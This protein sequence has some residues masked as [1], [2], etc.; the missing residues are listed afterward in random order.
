MLPE[1]LQQKLDTLPNSAGVYYFTGKRGEPLY[2]GKAANLRSRVRSYFQ[3]GNSDQRYFIDR[4]ARELGDIETFVT[5]T[6]REA[7]L[8]E[9]GLIKEH[10]PRYNVKL[11]DDKEYLSLRLDPAAA[12]PR[13]EVVRRPRKDG[14]QYFGPYHSATAARSTLRV[15]NRH[16]QL[17]T[18]TDR[19]LESR[20]RPCLQYQIKRC[21]GPCVYEIDQDLY[22]AQVRNVG[23][24]LDGRHDEL[25]E[26]LSTAMAGAATELKYEL[27]A[28]YR[29]QLRALDATAQKQRVALVSDID[30]DVF[31]F[32]R[33]KDKAELAVVMSRRGRVVGVR[34]FAL[35]Q[36]QIPDDELLSAFVREY[37]SH[38]TF[39]PNEVIVPLPLEAEVG[40]S[41]VLG[42]QAGH[43]VHIVRPQRGARAQ[44]LRMA[45]ENA[46]HAFNEKARAREDIDTRLS[47]VQSRLQLPR[48]PQRF[49]CVDVSHLGGG[50]TVAAVVSFFDGEPER[51]R[52]RSFH[53]KKV[54]GGDDYGAM[55]EVLSRRFRRAKRGESGWE[56]P[57]LLVVDG[58]KG[59]LGIAQQVLSE[60]ELSD[61]PVAGLAKEKQNVRGEQLVDRLY[62]PGRMNAI[63]LSSAGAAFNM[64]AYA[65][66]EAHRASNALRL[67]L[68]K[69]RRLRSRLDDIRGVGPKTRSLL[70]TAFGDLQGVEAANMEQL[71]AAGATR[72]QASAIYTHFHGDAREA[73][74]SEED[75]IDNAFD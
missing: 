32:Y 10:Q 14:A 42:E 71:V 66:D 1:A 47:L 23:L 27:A 24:F 56:L 3:L 25:R 63:E 69:R 45:M 72:R 75:A 8:L 20:T 54:R 64:F 53:V 57:D 41:E 67:K 50:D 13:L 59:Q 37:Y 16:F 21:P 29:D 18:C 73:D 17:R 28:T 74:A 36:V 58:G 5:E 39:V 43:R 49:E 46:V 12:Y 2:V 9:N 70:L 15:V 22:R 38:G 31:G 19:E 33:S 62:L 35:R 30:Q 11:R 65:R 26:Q 55:H 48:P 52:Y 51:K 60:L 7:T 6:E 61:L 44:L 40:V 68:G 4:L 34:T